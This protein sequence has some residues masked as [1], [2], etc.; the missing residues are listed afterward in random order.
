MWI[1]VYCDLDLDDGTHIRWLA[2]ESIALKLVQLSKDAV[3][4]TRPTE[5]TRHHGM[6]LTVSICS[7]GEHSGGIY[8]FRGGLDVEFVFFQLICKFACLL[9]N[10]IYYFHLM[11][12]IIILVQ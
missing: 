11:K 4:N 5:D 10:P 7:H 2:D 9:G 8:L 3:P 1:T 6:L 12:L